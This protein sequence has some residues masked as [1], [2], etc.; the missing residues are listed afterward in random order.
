LE[1]K[2]INDDVQIVVK[3]VATDIQDQT[4]LLPLW[5]GIPDETQ[6]ERLVQDSIMNPDRYWYP[7]GIPPQMYR[8][9]DE[10]EE[11]FQNVHL[12][13]N[14][15]IA[16]GMLNYGYREEVAEL[17]NRL[18]KAII[19]SLKEKRSFQQYYDAKTGQ[20]VGERNA[21]SG[22]AP[23]GLFLDTLGVRL[24]SSRKVHLVGHNP[25]PWPVTIKYLGISVLR[26]K[27]NTTV[28][29]PDGHSVVV[30]DPSPQ[31]VFLAQDESDLD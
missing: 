25:F 31:Y 28:T 29:F 16:E 23:I 19:K 8:V 2:G 17:V 24:I 10:P 6:V 22:L 13:W 9:G 3:S 11:M 5:A 4:N 15:L 21:I 14:L 27:R 18:M 20:G 1:F 30:D 12:I 26:G 7:F